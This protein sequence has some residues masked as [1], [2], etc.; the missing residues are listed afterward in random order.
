MTVSKVLEVPFFFFLFW[1]CHDATLC[2]FVL[3]KEWQATILVSILCQKMKK[4]L[5][6]GG[7]SNKF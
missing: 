5:T 4:Q 6:C 2:F 1:K 7:E 3:F